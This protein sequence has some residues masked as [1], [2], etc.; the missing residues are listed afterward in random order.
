MHS[1][2]FFFVGGGGGGR[3]KYTLELF[4]YYCHQPEKK[5]MNA[6]SSKKYMNAL[7]TLEIIDYKRYKWE[8]KIYL[9]LPMHSFFISALGRLKY[10]FELFKYYCLQLND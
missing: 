1:F 10:T 9:S 6:L 4:K 3:L 5:Y 7:I 8:Y 2:F